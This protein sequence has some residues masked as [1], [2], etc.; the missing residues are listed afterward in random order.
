VAVDIC[1]KAVNT[2]GLPAKTHLEKKGIIAMSAADFFGKKDTEKGSFEIMEG[3]GKYGVGVK[4][5]PSTAVFSM[6][7]EKPVVSYRFLAEEAGEYEVE[8][9][10]APTNSVVNK[11]SVNVTLQVNE[12]AP[13]KVTVVPAD[14]RAGESGDWRWSEGVLNQERRVRTKV[15]LQQGI[16]TI[17]IGA[18]EAGTV[19]ERVVIYRNGAA[20]KDVKLS[21]VLLAPGSEFDVDLDLESDGEYDTVHEIFVCIGGTETRLTNRAVSEFPISGLAIGCLVGLVPAAYLLVR[22]I[23]GCYYLYQERKIDEKSL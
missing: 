7:E 5:F 13:V 23:Q 14:F 22:S 15:Q 1:A 4:V 8:L 6:E 16:Q 18:M 17:G 9:V 3:Y 19:L 10:V 20:K 21:G 12:D 2:A 11:Q